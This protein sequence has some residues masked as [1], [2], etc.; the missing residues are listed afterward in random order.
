MDGVYTTPELYADSQLRVSFERT[1]VATQVIGTGRISDMKAWATDDGVLHIVGA[2]AGD[3]LDVYTS[4]GK[5][6]TK[7][8]SDGHSQEVSLPTHGVYIVRSAEKTIK[9]SY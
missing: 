5:H 7:C 6:L 4:D 3:V 1:G 9:L 8:V 2:E